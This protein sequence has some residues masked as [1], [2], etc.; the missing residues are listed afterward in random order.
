MANQSLIADFL[1]R[2]AHAMEQGGGDL[3]PVLDSFFSDDN[4]STYIASLSQY[5]QTTARGI[6]E[7]HAVYLRRLHF[8]IE[9]W[10]EFTRTIGDCWTANEDNDA[11]K[12]RINATTKI[13][14]R[15]TQICLD[16]IALFESG[17]LATAMSL[18]RS[19]Y[20]NYVVSLYL[21]LVDDL[22]SER[23]NDHVAAEIS[24]ILDIKSSESNQ[25]RHKHFHRQY[26]WTAD[27]DTHAL[28]FRE[29]VDHVGES[30]YYQSY[31]LAS[32]FVHASSLSVN[33]NPFEGST[34]DSKTEIGFSTYAFEIPYNLTVN[35]F[36]EHLQAMSSFFCPRQYAIANELFIKGLRNKFLMKEPGLTTTQGR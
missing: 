6:Q 25:K 16:M 27:T 33:R 7:S 1:A 13:L 5:R 3:Q 21:I 26:G 29:I 14:L 18:W 4:I 20:E 34:P 15:S 28:T 9:V 23:F 32:A 30:T 17:S 22:V 31:K 8:L 36:C 35:V 19:I 10:T 11:T 12:F 2:V 24:K